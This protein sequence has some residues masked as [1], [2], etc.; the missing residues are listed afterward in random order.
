[1]EQRFERAPGIKDDDRYVMPAPRQ[2]RCKHG[3]LALAAAD[4]EVADEK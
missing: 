2:P 3:E 4:G 1:L